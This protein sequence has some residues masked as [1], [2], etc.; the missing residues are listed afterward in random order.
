MKK[1]NLKT[2]RPIAAYSLH[3]I[4]NWQNCLLAVDSITGYL[5][6]IDPDTDNTTILNTLHWRDFVGSTGIAIAGDTIW[7]TSRDGIYVGSLADTEWTPQ[8]LIR[9]EDPPDGVAV[10]ESTLYVT[11][12]KSGKIYVFDRDSGKQITYIYAPGIGI[13]NIIVK[14]EELWISDNLEQ[15]VYCLDRATG[16]IIY[17]ILTP[18]QSPTGLAFYE[19]TLYVSYAF[20]EPYIRDNPNRETNYELQYRD[21][22]FIHPLH[23]KYYP[24]SKYALSNGYRLEMTYVEEISPLDQINLQ[25]LEWRI[26]LPAETNRQKVINIEAIGLP[27]TEEVKE[28]GHKVAVFKFDRLTGDTRCIFGWRAIIEVWSIK[29][30]LTPKDCESLPPLPEDYQSR[31]LVD[32]DDLA[33]GTE[34]IRRAAQEAVKTET[35]PLRK[36]YSIRNYVYDHLSYGL[37]PHIDTP[38]IALKRGVGSCGEYLGVLLALSRLNSIPSRTVGRYKCPPYPDRQHVPLC[39]D[40]NHV[41]M[42]FYLPGFGWLPMESNPDDLFDGGPYPNRFFMGLA[43]YHAEMAK[44]VSFEQV[45]TQGVPLKELN[46]SIGELALNHVQFIVLDDVIPD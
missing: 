18:F 44:G 24:E 31:Y 15:T 37:K 41:W 35:N 34:I 22:T 1:S 17:S 2:I 38:D 30:Q 12:Q 27:F 46:M 43:W 9:L 14:D 5:L 11:C 42:E 26:A 21:R 13:E 45:T 7:F 6:K 3:G 39:P 8:L 23:F 33:M 16:E 10:W 28:D 25:N 19:D 36:V 40:Y 20:Q 29:Y 32:D 4:A